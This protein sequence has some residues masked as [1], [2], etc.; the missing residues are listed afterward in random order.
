MVPGT[1]VLPG[2]LPVRVVEYSDTQKYLYCTSSIR[3][4][5]SRLYQVQVE[6]G[7]A[8]G[9]GC[10]RSG[11]SYKYQVPVAL[12]MLSSTHQQVQVPGTSTVRR[13]RATSTVLVPGSNPRGLPVPGRLARYEEARGA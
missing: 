11:L 3:L 13:K 10:A 5:H 8:T 7:N 9:A 12:Y 1:R 2:T 4:C 6:R